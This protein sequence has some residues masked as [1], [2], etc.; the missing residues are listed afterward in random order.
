LGILDREQ[1]FRRQQRN[2]AGQRLEVIDHDGIRPAESLFETP[3]VQ[4]PTQ[5]GELDRSVIRRP[6][7]RQGRPPRGGTGQLVQVCRDHGRQVRV[8]GIVERADAL[9]AVLGTR[10]PAA[11]VGA[12]D[13]DQ[14]HRI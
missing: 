12:A 3:P 6:G 8:I 5:V 11:R 7:R 14:Q 10:D 4:C 13:L 1:F 9:G 2:G